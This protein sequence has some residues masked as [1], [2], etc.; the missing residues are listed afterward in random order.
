M[1]LLESRPE[2]ESPSSTHYHLWKSSHHCQGH[3]EAKVGRRVNLKD[4]KG[5]SG[6]RCLGGQGFVFNKPSLLL[7]KGIS[8]DFSE[9]K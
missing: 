1:T 2:L 9:A 5:H 8:G 4:V 6:A 3:P 7:S